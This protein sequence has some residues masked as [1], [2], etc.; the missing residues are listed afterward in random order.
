MPFFGALIVGS[1]IFLIHN[2]SVVKNPI[3][4]FIGQ[5]VHV[6]GKASSDSVTIAEK[7]VGS[8]KLPSRGTFLMRAEEIR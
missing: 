8:R 5:E 3:T 4:N 7:V 1:L 2:F 6:R